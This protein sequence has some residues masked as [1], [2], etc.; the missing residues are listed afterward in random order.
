MLHT[1]I[2]HAFLSSILAI[3]LLGLLHT[4]LPLCLPVLLHARLCLMILTEIIKKSWSQDLSK[5]VIFG[6]HIENKASY[7]T[8]C[9][10]NMEIHSTE[11]LWKVSQIGHKVLK[12]I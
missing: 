5:T 6:I 11:T 10:V 2:N 8:E 7:T 1:T 3:N 9:K 12:L 4:H